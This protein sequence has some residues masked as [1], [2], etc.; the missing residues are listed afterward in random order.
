MLRFIFILSLVFNVAMGASILYFIHSKGGIS[1]LKEKL[2]LSCAK[3]ATSLSPGYATRNSIF[4]IM[5]KTKNSVVFLGDSIIEGCDWSE[6][7]GDSHILNRG[8]GGDTTS[9]ALL[10]LN[11]IIRRAPEKIFILLG[12]NDL[13]NNHSRNTASDIK[14]ITLQYEEIIKKIREKR[15]DTKIF[16][17][18]VTPVNHHWKYV[19]VTDAE[20]RLLNTSLEKLAMK[21]HVTYI[22]L[23]TEL[24]SADNQLNMEYTDDGLHLNGKGYLV[25]KQ[26]LQK[27]IGT[28]IH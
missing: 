1:Y 23:Y 20:I 2:H 7:F 3:V 6:L 11:D 14:K 10:R 25:C 8:I 27:Y 5:P 15:P 24:K 13:Y 18:S 17:L 26:V 28:P 22:D 9:G 12:G 4:K 21:Y 16:I 19:T